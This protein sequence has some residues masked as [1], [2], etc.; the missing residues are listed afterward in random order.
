MVDWSVVFCVAG[1]WVGVSWVIGSLIGWLCVAGWWVGVLGDW[2][3][4][5][6]ALCGWLMGGCPG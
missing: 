4:D 3:I 1:W 2:F 5:W 6:L